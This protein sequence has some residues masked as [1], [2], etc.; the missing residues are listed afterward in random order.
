MAGTSKGATAP[1]QGD[2]GAGIAFFKGGIHLSRLDFSKARRGKVGISEQ[3]KVTKQQL[4]GHFS[5]SRRAHAAA[6]VF[7]VHRFCGKS[8]TNLRQGCIIPCYP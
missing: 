6:C 5:F 1:R 7:I 2:F 8:D 3:R 4:N